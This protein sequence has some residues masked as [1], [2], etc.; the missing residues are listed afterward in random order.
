M[1]G[2]LLGHITRPTAAQ[3]PVVLKNFRDAESLETLKTQGEDGAVDNVYALRKV[4]TITCDGEVIP[5]AEDA[6]PDFPVV[7]ETMDI[8]DGEDTIEFMI[9]SAEKASAP[10]SPLTGTLTLERSDDATNHP[11]SEMHPATP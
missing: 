7:G 5:T 6:M 8:T 2:R 4:R 3:F 9:T 10:A 11:Y 1:A